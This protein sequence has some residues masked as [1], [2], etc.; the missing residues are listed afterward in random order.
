MVAHKDLRARVF[1]QPAECEASGHC[2][3]AAS[4]QVGRQN[5]AAKI[6]RLDYW[7]GEYL[8][9]LLVQKVAMTTITCIASASV[10]LSVL[11]LLVLL[12]RLRT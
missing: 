1:P 11:L 9:L 12:L 2:Y 6:E 8:A 7:L 10:R 5:Y 3:T 4:I